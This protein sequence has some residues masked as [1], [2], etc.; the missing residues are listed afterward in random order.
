[1][2]LK[3]IQELIKFV[4]VKHALIAYPNPTKEKIY[5]SNIDHETRVKI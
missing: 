3:D 2:D 4:V 5:V 1:M